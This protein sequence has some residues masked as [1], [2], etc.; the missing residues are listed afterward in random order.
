MMGSAT[1][2]FKPRHAVPDT[3]DF[4]T[5]F[6]SLWGTVLE[7]ALMDLKTLYEEDT[8]AWAENQAT[9]LRAAARDGSNQLLD[10]ENL[11]EEIESLRKSLKYALRSQIFRTI[12]HLVK[13]EYSPAIDPRNGWRRTIRQARVEIGHILED[14]PSLKHELASLISHEM[15]RAIE[16]A[17][18]DLQEFDKL[19]RLQLPSL[20]KVTY[21]PDQILGDWLPEEPKS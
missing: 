9:A 13:L 4:R 19:S 6:P 7:A 11:A 15:K 2:R 14:S 5:F 21:T 17:A 20:R 3:V 16:Y 18:D 8:A 12:H 1:L 10:W